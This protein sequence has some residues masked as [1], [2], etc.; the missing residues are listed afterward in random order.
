M[1]VGDKYYWK[2]N[3]TR[4]RQCLQLG[5]LCMY[6]SDFSFIKG[7]QIVNDQMGS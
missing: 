6:G 1:A 7:K 5:T 4:G 2:K 3:K